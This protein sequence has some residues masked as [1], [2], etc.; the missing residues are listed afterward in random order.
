MKISYSLNKPKRQR[1]FVLV[2]VLIAV[3]V[4]I[5]MAVAYL[6]MVRVRGYEI[7][8]AAFRVKAN[9]V[10]TLAIRLIKKGLALDGNGYDSDTERWAQEQVLPVEG[11]GNVSIKIIDEDRFV[12]LNKI[13]LPD[14]V[15]PSIEM[16]GVLRRIFAKY[17]VDDYLPKLLDFLDKDKKPRFGGDEGDV[18]EGFIPPNRPL[19]SVD[20]LLYAPW[21][22]K[23]I[24]NDYYDRISG[25]KVRGIKDY[26]TCWSG[27][28]I[29]I[30][31]APLW[32]LEVLDEEI[33]QDLASVIIEYRKNN[34]FRSVSDL[35][36]VPGF[37]EAVIPRLM[38]LVGVK[39]EYYKATIVVTGDKGRFAVD[40]VLKKGRSKV[41]LVYW[42]EI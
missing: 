31:T 15:T 32:V 6:N 22:D 3:T 27:G 13:L 33:D 38:N 4:L 29:N 12:P 8:N 30:N 9:V 34:P 41:D 23:K 11:V 39:S 28:K 16:K 10:A 14:G 5:T 42:K 25:K 19:L 1:G 26:F 35:K 37:P 24:F 17:N 18:F 20:E 36:N 7:K 40:V 21:M 2:S